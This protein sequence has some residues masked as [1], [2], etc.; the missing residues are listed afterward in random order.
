MPRYAH[1]DTV[2][3]TGRSRR[4]LALLL[5]CPV[6]PRPVV[7]ASAATHTHARRAEYDASSSRSVAIN[8]PVLCRGGA[9]SVKQPLLMANKKLHRAAP[10]ARLGMQ[11][12]YA[13]LSMIGECLCFLGD[14]ICNDFL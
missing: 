6:R 9:F 13:M 8:S 10:I 5:A 4:A 1:S 2:H 11:Q 14:R 12:R 3:L 7:V